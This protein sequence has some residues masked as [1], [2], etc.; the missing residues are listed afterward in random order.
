MVIIIDTKGFLGGN[1]SKKIVFIFIFWWAII[2][3]ELAIND[4]TADILPNDYTNQSANFPCTSNTSQM[5]ESKSNVSY[6]LWLNK[7]L[8]SKQ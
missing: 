6:E 5:Q 2:F 7:I 8:F 1:M 4:F 3:P